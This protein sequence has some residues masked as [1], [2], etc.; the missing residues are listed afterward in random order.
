MRE[1]RGVATSRDAARATARRDAA[2]RRSR[3][4]TARVVLMLEHGDDGALGIMLNRPS[5]ATLDDVLPEWHAFA[6]APGV[7]FSGRARSRPKP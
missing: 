7:V 5:E 3:T 2:A 1:D 6:S 4:S